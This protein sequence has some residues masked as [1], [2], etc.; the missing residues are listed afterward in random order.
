MSI[1]KFCIQHKVMTLLA[2]IMVSIFGLTFISQLQMAL[3]PD[4]NYPAAVVVCYYN[5]ASPSDM[6]E[7]VT[8]PLEEAV[9]SV[10]GVDE[11][12]STSADSMSQIQ[13]TYVEGTDL[14]I[15]ATKLREQFDM[16]TLPD[17][18]TKPVIV[19]MNISDMMP[20]AMI[21]L[22]GDN[23]ASL[24]RL[25]EDTVVPA[26]ERIDGVASVEVSGGV[27]EQIDV[28]LDATRAAGLGLSNSYISQIL[29]AQNLLYPGGEIDNGSKTLTV[30]TDAKFQSVED[31]ANM[32]VPLPAG[33]SVRLRDV[34]Q[35]ELAVQEPE[36]VAKVGDTACVILQVSKR[37]GGNEMAI[38][39]AIVDR[40]D[41]LSA[42]NA[43]IH[44]TAPYLASDYISQAVT[45]A[46]QN[47]LQG[48]ILAAVVVFLF[49]RRGGATATIAVS[50]PICILSVFL[51]MM[52][53]PVYEY[54][55]PGRHCHGRRHDRGQLD[56]CAGKYL[57]FFRRWARPH[58]RL[59]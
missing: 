24:Q 55:E 28:R 33:G 50:M 53:R 6:E 47:I 18:A 48:V 45:S 46:L 40:M 11:V 13:V 2:A 44:Y 9:M 12:S 16:L 37:S 59:Y 56:R 51:L 42:E 27:T 21:A 23:L 10:S 34:A 57:P 3:M 1:S 35:V 30:S 41:E 25:A 39:N 14:D 8:R 36:A 31:V 58:E 7:L 49:L 5:G 19:N 54:D 32:I 52:L 22:S 20:T 38:S 26:L 15:A 4:M 17:G 29:A 43:S